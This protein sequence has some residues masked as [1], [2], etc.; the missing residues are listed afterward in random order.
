MSVIDNGEFFGIKSQSAEAREKRKVTLL[1]K[2]KE[3]RAKIILMLAATDY[4][5][6]E[7]YIRIYDSIRTKGARYVEASKALNNPD[8]RQE[9]MDF[10]STIDKSLLSIEE[11]LNIEDLTAK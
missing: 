6:T 1:K 2:A 9:I 7:A 8:M 4:N 10:F 3:K 5:W 11:N